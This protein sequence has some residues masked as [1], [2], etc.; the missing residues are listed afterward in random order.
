MNQCKRKKPSPALAQQRACAH[1]AQQWGWK[2]T[3]KV[4]DTMHTAN[5]RSSKWQIFKLC[6]LKWLDQPCSRQTTITKIHF[7]SGS[8]HLPC[9]TAAWEYQEVTD[10]SSSQIQ[11]KYCSVGRRCPQQRMGGFFFRALKPPSSYES[12]AVSHGIILKNS[13]KIFSLKSDFLKELPKH[14]QLPH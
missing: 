8:H 11:N 12:L 10:L 7:L 3:C 5:R 14:K 9:K 4:A 2:S 1:Q 13:W 6:Y